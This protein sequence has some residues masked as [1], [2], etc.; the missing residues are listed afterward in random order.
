V[1]IAWAIGILGGLAVTAS[2]TA[3]ET[4]ISRP[5][6]PEANE[7]SGDAM[8]RG[9]FQA[10]KAAFDAGA[11]DEALTHFQ[12]AY[13]H[14]KRPEL[15]YNIGLAADRLRYNKAALQ[16]FETYQRLVPKAENRME[17]DN[18]IR[19]LRAVIAREA[20]SPQ[21]SGGLS[22]SAAVKE[23]TEAHGGAVERSLAPSSAPTAS[24]LMSRTLAVLRAT[25]V[26]SRIPGAHR[27]MPVILPSRRTADRAV[28]QAVALTAK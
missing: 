17:V 11:Y 3:Q 25:Q 6:E 21:T 15:L 27:K 7:A 12:E 14:S 9:L 19:A 1:R 8:A 20:G 5:A 16:A 22:P 18:R 26:M 10:G 23:P 4:S 24:E 28:A 2:V 13:D